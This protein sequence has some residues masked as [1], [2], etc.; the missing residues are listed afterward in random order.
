VVLVANFLASDDG[1]PRVLTPPR[2]PSPTVTQPAA[3]ICGA[4]LALD[5]RVPDG[6]TGPTIGPRQPTATTPSPDQFVEHWTL[7][8]GTIELR[9]PPDT[10]AIVPL[11]DPGTP[12]A[13]GTIVGGATVVGPPDSRGS[14]L[15][16][17]F[18]AVGPHDRAECQLAQID[19]LNTDPQ[20]RDL[21]FEKFLEVNAPVQPLITGSQPA[22]TVPPA[23]TCRAPAGTPAPPNIGGQVNEATFPTPEEALDAFVHEPPG[24][25]ESGYQRLDLPD[26]TI[27]YAAP[28]I[29]GDGFV[30]VIHM[31]RDQQ[32]WTV[33]SWDSSAC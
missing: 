25:I 19:I 28:V 3:G 23:I 15:T 18:V 17:T 32:G 9:W 5:L 10:D 11:L 8:T 20:Q 2:Q 24:R 26:G 12:A 33:D 27:A 14:Y 21:S 4:Q 29:T 22:D 6:F 7:A 1:G 16:R 13:S 30:T 31:K